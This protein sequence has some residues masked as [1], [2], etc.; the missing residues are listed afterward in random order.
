MHLASKTYFLRRGRADDGIKAYSN[1]PSLTLTLNG[2]DEGARR[3]GEH[4][5]PNGRAIANVFFWHA[6]LRPGRNEIRVR[7][8]AGHEDSAIVHYAPPGAPPAGGRRPPARASLE[9]PQSPA[10]FIDQEA[11]DQWPFYFECDGTADDTFDVL[12]EAVRG[13][14]WIATRRLSKPEARTDLSFRIAPDTPRATVYVMGSESPALAA[15]LARAGLRDTGLRGQ[16][17]DNTLRVVPF[18]LYAVDARGGDR[19][20]IP[21]VTAD[22]VVLVKAAFERGAAAAGYF[23]PHDPP[24]DPK[25]PSVSDPDPVRPSPIRWPIRR[26]VSRLPSSSCSSSSFR[27]RSSPS[28]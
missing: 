23:E 22:Y 15:A 25:A 14:R 7:D 20:A 18:R 1:A 19:V 21:G 24:E 4:R 17:R 2:T 12:P 10:W 16:W 8:G 27:S 13:A 28:A 5:H 26:S 6:S 3:N 9:Q 11:R